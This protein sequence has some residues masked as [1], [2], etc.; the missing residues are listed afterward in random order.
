MYR[1][2]PE[3]YHRQIQGKI[4][5]FPSNFCGIIIFLALTHFDI[6]KMRFKLKWSGKGLVRL[7]GLCSRILNPD[8]WCS[9]ANS[10]ARSQVE[11]SKSSFFL[12]R[13]SV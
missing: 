3:Q 12:A 9:R 5:S 4:V 1:E 2:V 13:V 10:P 11:P 8:S 6:M 7:F